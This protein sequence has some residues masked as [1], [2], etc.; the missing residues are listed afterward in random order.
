M[1][2]RFTA[3]TKT[4]EEEKSKTRVHHRVHRGRATEPAR[5]P[6]E[7]PGGPAVPRI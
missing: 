7:A 6:F 5:M 2:F 4:A 1:D 3:E